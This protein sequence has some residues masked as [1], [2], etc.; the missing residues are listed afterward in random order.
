MDRERALDMLTR[1]V[2]VP[3]Q[4][5]PG[6]G[7]EECAGLLADWLR[8]AGL[9]VREVRVPNSDPPRVIVVG[10][11][12]SGRPLY[13]HGH[14]DVVPGSPEQFVALSLIHI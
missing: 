5:P 8:S 2:E 4:N 12:G 10:E 11:A 14:Y 6:E 7:C 1:L 9:R 13:L 3:T